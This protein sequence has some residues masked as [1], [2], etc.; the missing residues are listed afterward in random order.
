MMFLN[1][2]DSRQFNKSMLGIIL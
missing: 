2:L 1:I